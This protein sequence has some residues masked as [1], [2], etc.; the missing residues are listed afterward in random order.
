MENSSYSVDFTE[1]CVLESVPITEGR[2]LRDLLLNGMRF[3]PSFMMI[4]LGIQVILRLLPQQFGRLQ[5]ITDG[6]NL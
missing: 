5:C 1:K 6:R 4:G 2:Y 3:I